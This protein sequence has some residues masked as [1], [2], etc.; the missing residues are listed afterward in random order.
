[1]LCHV[2]SGMRTDVTLGIVV[3]HSDVSLLRVCPRSNVSHNQL[4][5][6]LPVSWSNMTKIFAW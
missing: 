1:M 3:C 2:V 6:T 5:G 4:S